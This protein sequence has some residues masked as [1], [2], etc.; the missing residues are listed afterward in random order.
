[1][2]STTSQA[3]GSRKR[4]ARKIT[5]AML[6]KKVPE[7]VL[8]HVSTIYALDV[9]EGKIPACKLR[10]AACQRQLDD[11]VY[12]P[13]R[14]LYFSIPRADHAIRFFGYLRHS[15]GK[16]G[17]Q[18]FELANWQAFCTA[19]M[20]GWL[21]ESTQKRRFRMAYIEVP[22]KNGKSTF[23]SP[24]G[25]YMMVAD[26]EPG[27]QVYA[28]ATK[29]D[30]AKIVFDEAAKMARTSPVLRKRVRER[31]HHMEHP[32]SFS[33]FKYISADGKRLDGLNSH[34]NIID[35][36]H[37]HPNRLLIDVLRTGTGAREQPL[38]VE[39][40]T[41]GADP[42]SICRE[43]HDYTV[44]VL[45]GLFENDGWFGFICSIDPGDDPFDELS[46]K[47]ANPNYGISVFAD[48][49][50]AEFKEAEDNPSALAS[51]MRLY[52]N[53]WSQ[54]AEIWLDIEKWR[55]CETV[56]DRA[57]MRGRRCYIGLDFG[58]VSD[59][60]ALVLV[61][62]PVDSGEPVK[63][64]PF[65]WVP[66]G[67]IEKRRVDQAVPY[68]VW[69]RDG[70]IFQTE[71]TATN[72]TAIEHFII[73]DDAGNTGLINEFEVMEVDYDRYF[74]GQLIQ[75]LEER[76]VLCVAFG[77]GYFSM[78]APCRELERLV[79]EGSIAHDGNPVMDW[80]IANTAVKM[81]DSG[82]M[83]PIK[84]D[85]RKDMRKIDGV[86]AMLMALGRMISAEEDSNVIS[87]E[88][89]SM[90]G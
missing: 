60:T 65:F 3:T 74:A 30:Q 8:G 76:G 58:A 51:K 80:M 34:C 13:K 70:L 90:F 89:G 73:G 10:I 88:P 86:V 64:M 45:K 20:F 84:P 5:R 62:P 52:L 29:A 16:W 41:A 14:G 33:V 77:Q 42:H 23:L 72:Y 4:K 22:R 17:G 82:N 9:V 69:L 47:K 63:I 26:G 28:A 81:D 40:T 49:L 15:T 6:A 67:T 35:E 27:A 43:H 59:I 61:F 78:A 36:V 85:T 37:A 57:S 31:A 44:N 19:V 11:L 12:G 56:Y 1:M 32:K 66:L 71:G 48:G 2:T 53:V 50:K 46:W 55:A 87:Y 75:H 21:W 25:L 24:I 54:T 79:L 7:A 38:T 39:I 68:D 18:V 83:R